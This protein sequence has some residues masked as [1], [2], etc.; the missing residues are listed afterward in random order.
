MT[1]LLKRGGKGAAV[2]D[3]QTSLNLVV[4]GSAGFLT[5][6]GDFGLTTEQ[7]VRAFQR[8]YGLV[9]DG[10]AGPQTLVALRQATSPAKPARPEP[11]K[12]AMN[13]PATSEAVAGTR[14]APPP[15]AASLRLLDTAR[16]ISEIIFHCTA[17]PE[18]KDYTVD[19]IRAWHKER[20]WS[21]IGYHY[22]VYRDGRVMLGRPVGQIG[23]HVEGHNTGTIGVSYVGGVSADGKTAKD[24]RTPAQRSSLLWLGQQLAAKHRGVRKV[25][26]HNQYAAKACPSFSVPRDA[27]GAI[28]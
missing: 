22:V 14:A 23:A 3:L 7:A 9:D 8:T 21:D 1:T 5:V 15:N 26:G 27:L 18:G 12:S 20:G 4:A 19:D 16:P 17:T 25:S 28:V 24:T 6:D 11:G 13:Q 10:I 2:R